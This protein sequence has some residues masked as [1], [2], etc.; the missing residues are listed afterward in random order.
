M[1]RAFHERLRSMKLPAFALAVTS[2]LA[3]T[4]SAQWDHL[5]QL[6]TNHGS[7]DE[8]PVLEPGVVYPVDTRNWRTLLEHTDVDW[9]VLCTTGPE[10]CPGC[11]IYEQDAVAL[12]KDNKDV[13][14]ARIDCDK[15][16]LLCAVF[17]SWGARVY[18]VTHSSKPSKSFPGMTERSTHLRPVPFHRPGTET[19]APSPSGAEEED[20]KDK[21][22]AGKRPPPPPDAHWLAEVAREGRWHELQEWTGL[23]QPFEGAAKEIV[24]AWW[25]IVGVFSGVPPMAMMVGIGLLSRFVTSRFTGRM[26]PQRRQEGA[27]AAPGAAPGAAGA[28]GAA[29]K[30]Q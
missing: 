12:L 15:Q 14:F 9:L 25:W 28:A 29:R 1:W 27:P 13:Y 22:A 10:N 3:A 19:E 4:V 21:T 26:A 30:R 7:T 20:P 5:Q 24:F 16:A 18:H 2:V 6:L 23:S 8:A 17:S 11:G